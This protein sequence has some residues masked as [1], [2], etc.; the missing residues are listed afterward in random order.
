MDLFGS[1]LISLCYVFGLCHSVQDCALLPFPTVSVPSS[2]SFPEAGRM[3]WLDGIIDSAESVGCA[4][5]LSRTDSAT[6]WIAA[7]QASL[8]FIFS[9]SLLKLM[10]IESEMLLTVSSSASPLSFCFQSFPT[11]GS[12][13]VSQVFASVGQSFGALVSASVLPMSI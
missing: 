3:R 2:F 9:Q 8:S 10:S 11:S 1:N 13:P 12:F 6:P 7:H 5:W 4:Q